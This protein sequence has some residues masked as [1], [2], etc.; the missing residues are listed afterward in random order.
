MILTK[1][2]NYHGGCL[3]LIQMRRKSNGETN[4]SGHLQPHAIYPIVR[5]RTVEMTVGIQYN[6][7]PKYWTSI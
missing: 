7:V 1:P 6:E 2:S 3:P 4:G 5:G